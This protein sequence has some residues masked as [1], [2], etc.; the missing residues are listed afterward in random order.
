MLKIIRDDISKMKADALVNCASSSPTIGP[1]VESA[2]FAKGKRW[3]K[4]NR[5][6]LGVIEHGHAA[7]RIIGVRLNLQIA[8]AGQ[9]GFDVH[10]GLPTDTKER[11]IGG[12]RLQ[13]MNPPFDDR[14]CIIILLT[15]RP[16][17]SIAFKTENGNCE[18]MRRL[19]EGHSALYGQGRAWERINAV[20]TLTRRRGVQVIG[21]DIVDGGHR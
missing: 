1:G 14:R 7:R 8:R 4:A 15:E 5:E 9:F 20:L 11:I 6:K 19:A 3:L 2:L 17:P 12:S 13:H 18:F 21:G 16:E 10:G